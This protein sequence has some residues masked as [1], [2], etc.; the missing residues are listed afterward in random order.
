MRIE[1]NILEFFSR[2]NVLVFIVL[3]VLL[4]I[5][6]RFTEDASI[7]QDQLTESEES[8]QAENE[9]AIKELDITRS[10]VMERGGFQYQG[11]LRDITGGRILRKIT[12]N[13][14]AQ[15]AA[16]MWYTNDLF[17]LRATFVNLPDPDGT[18]FY[19][20]WIVREEDNHVVS[21]GPLAQINGEW[22]NVFE[23]SDNLTDHQKYILTLEPDDSD[24]APYH[25]HIVE[26]ILKPIN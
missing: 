11:T 24:P 6:S 9:T 4:L 14:H 7:Q 19:E 2:K 22:V 1:E 10:S 17:E 12:T 26:G 23:S 3:V 20:G 25:T 5:V 18:D 13:T 21:T 8:E 16:Q 15:G